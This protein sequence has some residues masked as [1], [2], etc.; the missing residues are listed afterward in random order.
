MKIAWFKRAIS[1]EIGCIIA[2]YAW[3]DVSVTKQDD[4]YMTGLCCDDGVKK[5][6]IL[7]FDLLALD[8]WYIQ[9]VRKECATILGTEESC[10]LFTCTHNHSGPQTISE[11]CH[12]DALNQPY[13]DMLEKAILEETAGLQGKYV[14]V[15]VFFY[16]ANVDA[17]RNRRYVTA[18]NCASFLP[19]RRELIPLADGFTDQEFGSLIFVASQTR[20]P[21]YVIGNYAAHPLAGHAP[22]LGGL[23]ISADFP[24]HFRNYVTAETGA[25]CM[26]IC[27]ATGNMVPKEDE[28][29]TDAAKKLGIRLGKAMLAA[30]VDAPRNPARFKLK[31]PKVGGLIRIF[32]APLRPKF[33]DNPKNL[34]SYYLAKGK[35]ESE[36]QIV[37]IGDIAFVGLPGEPCAELG[38][39]IKWHSPY[40]RTYIAYCATGYVDYICPA[41]FLVAGGYEAM[42]HRFSA[43]NSID[44]IKTAVDG[45]FALRDT[46]FTADAKEMYPDNLDLPLVCLPPNRD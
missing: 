26:Y 43:R 36:I 35:F 34:A 12:E 2:G 6:L 30:M 8:E 40:R 24:G 17:N 28:L 21:V 16:S 37:S 13:V 19:A 14:D 41:N 15:E 46:I 42:T 25:E 33:K 18:D 9:R 7:S 23:R 38:L 20:Q 11:A 3:N 44:L 10:V 1:P 4:I 32:T 45:L 31:E 22:G 29:G 5:I 39:E 27:G